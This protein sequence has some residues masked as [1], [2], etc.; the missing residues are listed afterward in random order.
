MATGLAL[1]LR[2]G[3][4]YDSAVSRVLDDPTAAGRE[5]F[6]RHA[7]QEAYDSLTETDGS[8]LLSGEGLQMLAEAS[9]WSGHSE[10]VLEVG[11][12]AYGAYMEDGNLPA[13]AMMAYQLSR[14]YGMRLAGPTSGGWFARAEQLVANDPAS[15]VNGYLAFMR[16]FLALQV[17]GDADKAIPYLDEALKI[18]DRTGDRNVYGQSLHAKGWALAKQGKLAEALALMD[19]AMVAAVGGE[20]D[21]VTTGEVYCGMIGM[22][23]HRGDYKRAAEW[24]DATLRWCERNS[25]TGFPGICRV[26]RAGLMRLHGA[27][28]NAEE[29]ARLAS[30]ELMKFKLLFAMGDAFYEIGEVRRRMG[31][32]AGAEESFGRAHEYGLD[33]QPGLSLVRLGQ[34][35]IEVAA[36]GIRR[37]LA[38]NSD[39]RLSRVRPLVA[40]VEIAIAAGDLD[41]AA[42]ASEE[43][44]SIVEEVGTTAYRAEGA[45]A[46]GAVRL[47]RGDP[48]GS[49][50]DLRSALHGWQELEAPYEAAELRVLLGKAYRAL[51]DD[52]GA[53][54][55]L[56]AARDTFQRLGAAWAVEKTGELLGELEGSGAKR[57][58]V[59]RAFMFTD[60]IKSTDLVGAIGDEAWEDLLS[61]HDQTLRS[62]FAS[63]G[64]EV[65]NHTGDGFFVAFPDT[66]SALTAAIAIHRALAEHRRETGF[67]P[68]VRIGIHAAEATRRGQDYGGGEVHKAA[69]IAA[70]A[71][72]WEILASEETLAEA[73]G[74]KFGEIREVSLK[75]IAKP[76]RVALVEWR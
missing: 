40:Q 37:A 2:V 55:E 27:W 45:R 1:V 10:A 61:W 19:E 24:T 5:A 72:G 7:W 14:Q 63:H 60:I 70:Q 74:F 33:P 62:K 35:K 34:G 38:E 67:A 18:A 16:G 47:A 29:E 17:E 8:G 3:E 68:V 6:E 41:T 20:M 49:I 36:A 30:D 59:K 69:R 48:G 50:A 39:D 52:E 71:D 65:A 9:F 28:H 42:A 56:R 26:H 31:D 21:P 64:G 53:L 54:M 15:P 58:R 22:C 51:G 32:F 57:E 25:I 46:R 12:R 4:A 73:E 66:R 13:A 11:E 75:G 76:V 43:L 44:A 23:F